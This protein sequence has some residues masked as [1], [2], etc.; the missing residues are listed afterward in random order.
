MESQ[1]TVYFITN[2]LLM[3]LELDI[4][5]FQTLDGKLNIIYSDLFDLPSSFIGKFDGVWDRGSIVAIHPEDRQKYDA[6]H[7]SQKFFN[8]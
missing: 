2:L 6:N 8:I 3:K 7:I 1:L 5:F 4:K